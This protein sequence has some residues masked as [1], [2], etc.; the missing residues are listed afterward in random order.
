MIRVTRK[1]GKVAGIVPFKYAPIIYLASILRPFTKI[2]R[3]YKKFQTWEETKQLWSPSEYQ[4]KF[5]MPGLKQVRV[6][7]LLGTFLLNIGV[8]GVKSNNCSSFDSET[9]G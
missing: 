1:G 6:Q 5:E 8:I 3:G 9:G 4:T 7:L 2:T